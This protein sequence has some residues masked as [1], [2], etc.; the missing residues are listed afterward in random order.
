MQLMNSE[1]SLGLGIGYGQNKDLEQNSRSKFEY[2]MTTKN[3]LVP[4]DTPDHI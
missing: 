4:L 1:K 2:Q 3:A